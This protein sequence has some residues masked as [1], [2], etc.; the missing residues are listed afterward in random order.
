MCSRFSAPD[1]VR[2]AASGELYGDPSDKGVAGGV[3]PTHTPAAAWLSAAFYHYDRETDRIY[4][5][6][7]KSALDRFGM[8]GVWNKM[9]SLSERTKSA[10]VDA[11]A[12]PYA[13]ANC[14][15]V[16]LSMISDGA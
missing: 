13:L 4:A 8:Y 2:K 10:A 7:I 11:G 6:R 15:S 1:F 3:Y 16:S 14:L 9:A 5:D 12:D